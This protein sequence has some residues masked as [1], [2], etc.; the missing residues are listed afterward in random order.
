MLELIWHLDGV[1]QR[2]S[3][4]VVIV[5]HLEI[6]ISGRLK[7]TLNLFLC[8]ACTRSFAAGHSNEAVSHYNERGNQGYLWNYKILTF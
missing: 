3:Q 2:L 7:R 1:L 4:K 6:Q 5:R 8:T